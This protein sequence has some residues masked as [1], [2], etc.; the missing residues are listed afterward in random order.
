MVKAILM[1]G[2]EG[3]KFRTATATKLLIVR[4]LKSCYRFRLSNGVVLLWN[5]CSH[6]RRWFKVIVIRN[7]VLAT[8]AKGIRTVRAGAVETFSI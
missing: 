3:K 5:C 6:W 7:H 1:L 8:Q 2:R 4:F